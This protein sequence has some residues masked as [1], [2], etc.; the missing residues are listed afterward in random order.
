MRRTRHHTSTKVDTSTPTPGSLPGY[1]PD[2]VAS[3]AWHTVH[4]M[5]RWLWG[6]KR[7]DGTG[8]HRDHTSP[9]CSP[10]AL[11]HDTTVHERLIHCMKWKAAFSSMW[12]IMIRRC[13]VMVALVPQIKTKL[14]ILIF[15]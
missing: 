11:H 13:G 9:T 7:W 15:Q 14:L 4:A 1:A 5:G 10:C 8:P 3:H 2:L 12:L 6:H